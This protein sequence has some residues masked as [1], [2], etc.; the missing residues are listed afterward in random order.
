MSA[1]RDFGGVLDPAPADA[2]IAQHMIVEP[3]QCAQGPS[4]PDPGRSA[5]SV[6][7]MIMDF[8]FLFLSSNGDVPA[9]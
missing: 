6:E 3:G 9:L 8:S 7:R 5:R 2:D 4:V 1:N